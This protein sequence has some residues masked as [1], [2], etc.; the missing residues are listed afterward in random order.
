MS[1][2]TPS[3]TSPSNSGAGHRRPDLVV[4]RQ[5]PLGARQQPLAGRGQRHP[6]PVAHEQRCAQAVL[7]PLQLLAH[8][9][10]GQ[11][12]RHRRPGDAA[13]LGDRHEAPQQRRVDVP[14][15]APSSSHP[16]P[17]VILEIKNIRF[18]YEMSGSK[19][20][21]AAAVAMEHR[22][23]GPARRAPCAS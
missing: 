20:R 17:I 14:R 1:R 6:L 21:I 16:S 13:R 7:Q 8:R 19:F 23:G 22:R 18:H 3:L 10:L 5:H 11:V 15:H 4:D 12:Q 9:R 2:G